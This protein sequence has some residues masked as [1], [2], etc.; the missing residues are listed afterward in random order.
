MEK[1]RPKWKVRLIK[2][3]LKGH[4]NGE[5]MP[6][7]IHFGH[8]TLDD[9]VARIAN[10]GCALS[11]E[12]LRHAVRLLM[13]EVEDCIVKGAVVDL[14]IGRLSPGMTGTWESINRIDPDV[15][16]QNKAVVNYHM[17]TR[18]KRALA[19]PLFEA[20]AMGA[21][22]SLSIHT[23]TDLSSRSENE[24]ITPGKNLIVEGRML[25][26]N[27]DLPERGLY[28]LDADTQEEVLHVR[29]EEMVMN[30]RQRIVV[31]LPA[32]LPEGRY[33]LRVVS[34]CSTSP[35]PMRQAATYTMKTVLTCM[36]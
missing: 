1:R 6:H 8:Y 35:R 32:D 9:L 4:E 29:P 5:W 30:T 19:D 14:P 31:L 7:V 12:N 28:L 21:S 26:M 33:L 23:V 2:S 34:Q 36:K 18:M 22:W 17:S 13:D 10:R 15:R 27:G 25:L 20:V 24:R 3:N 16:A 11:P